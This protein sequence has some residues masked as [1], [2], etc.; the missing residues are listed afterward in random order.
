LKEKDG[1]GADDGKVWR[2]LSPS[3]VQFAGG[4]AE[5]PKEVSY[6]RFQSLSHEC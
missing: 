4:N 1:E 2:S 5:D 3:T 6:T